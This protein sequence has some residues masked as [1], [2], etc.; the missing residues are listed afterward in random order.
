MAYSNLWN[1]AVPTGAEAANTI[2]DI[3]R[4]L[5]VDIE[6]R[7]ND[8]FGGMP[9]FATDPLRPYGLRFTDAQDSVIFL[10]DNAGTP[11]NLDIKDK[12]GTNT[13]LTLYQNGI[14]L[15]PVTITANTPFFNVSQ[16]WNN[17]A[18]VFEGIA[19]NII[20]TA[21]STSSKLIDL[22]VGGVSQFSATVGGVVAVSSAMTIASNAVL[23]AGNF[24]TFA[25]TLTGTG[26][27]G[28]WGINVTG[29]SA[30]IT[31]FSINQNL[32]TGNNVIFN[33]VNTTGNVVSGAG[34]FYFN[35]PATRSLVFDGVN[36][37]FVGTGTSLLKIEGSN[38]I[39]ASD[40]GSVFP[41]LT[42][43][44]ASG[45]WGISISGNAATATA[46][47]SGFT[48][49]QNLNTTS[50]VTFNSVLLTN[51]NGIGKITTTTIT[52]AN[53]AT[54]VLAAGVSASSHGTLI[55]HASNGTTCLVNLNGTGTQV[56][57]FA[58]GTFSTGWNHS[59]ANPGTINVGVSAG[60]LTLEN[61]SGGSLVFVATFFGTI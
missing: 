16:T 57:P 41:S 38:V 2:D 20:N 42:G 10:G 43:T 52:L 39:K 37:L 56:S 3:F 55:C 28:T 32:G 7:F 47:A 14:N 9:S 36:F 27:S 17:A 61:N 12:T 29:T 45:T 6:Q 59:L 50:D 8:I 25:P 21:S 51:A 11:R 60:N 19:V 33:Q 31:A 48:F 15:T 4:A 22:Q 13:Y 23:H 26:A 49:N 30:N 40:S 44:G 35:T 54:Q 46:F 34:G 58:S 24:N 53:T 18:I 1:D 5:K